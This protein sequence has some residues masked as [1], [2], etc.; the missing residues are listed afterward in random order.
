MLHARARH[1][2]GERRTRLLDLAV[3]M[4]PGKDAKSLTR[5]SK[6][7]EKAS[8]PP[9]PKLSVEAQGDADVSAALK[10]LMG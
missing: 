6:E 2:A 8:K 1:E 3:A 4:H 7:L 5:L 9:R 10:H